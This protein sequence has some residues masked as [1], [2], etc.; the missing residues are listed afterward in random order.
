MAQD[1]RKL[2]QQTPISSS[3]RYP[4]G[5]TEPYFESAVLGRQLLLQLGDLAAGIL[6]QLGEAALESLDILDELGDL[7]LLGS[8]LHFQAGACQHLDGLL[9]QGNED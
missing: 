6:P 3:L 7:A 5:R 1:Q 2:T 8:Q 4:W 9:L